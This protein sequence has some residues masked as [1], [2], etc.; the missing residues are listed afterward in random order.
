MEVLREGS[1]ACAFYVFVNSW[2][3]HSIHYHKMP[4]WLLVYLGFRIIIRDILNA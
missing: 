1:R 2:V 3:A 4:E